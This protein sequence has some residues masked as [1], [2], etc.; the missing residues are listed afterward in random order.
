MSFSARSI[1]A[2]GSSEHHSDIEIIRGIRI[3]V[4]LVILSFLSASRR[5]LCT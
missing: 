1:S 5:P 3:F 4:L 2:N